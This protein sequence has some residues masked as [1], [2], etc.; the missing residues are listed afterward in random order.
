M[1]ETARLAQERQALVQSHLS[2]NEEEVRWIRSLFPERTSYTDV[3]GYAGMLGERTIMAHCVH[4]TDAE[5]SL[6]AAA[7]TNIVFC[8]YSNRVL[9]SGTMPYGKLQAAGLKI[10]LGSDIAGGPS[11]SMCRQMGEALNS[12]NVTSAC[13]SPVGALYLA[14]LAGAEV[15]GLADRI[16]NLAPGKDADFVLVDY[17]RADPLSGAGYYTAPSDILSRLC[18]NGD[19]SCVKA[20]Y[21]EAIRVFG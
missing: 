20:V 4:L 12:A 9:R 8:P 3:Y 2:E 17:K 15:L 21:A 16:G 6:L 5:V 19:S 7:G 10:A 18:F 14:T 1:R 13:L 11:L